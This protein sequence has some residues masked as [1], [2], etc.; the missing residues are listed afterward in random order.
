MTPDGWVRVIEEAAR[1]LSVSPSTA[2][3]DWPAMVVVEHWF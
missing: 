1:V 2:K 3:R